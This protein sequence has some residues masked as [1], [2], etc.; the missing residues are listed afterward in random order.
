[1][2]IFQPQPALRQEQGTSIHAGHYDESLEEGCGPTRR[3]QVPNIQLR[4]FRVIATVVQV[5][6]MYMIIGT[7]TLRVSNSLPRSNNLPTPGCS[8][9]KSVFFCR[10]GGYFLDR[11]L[12]R[13]DIRGRRIWFGFFKVWGL[14]VCVLVAWNV[15]V[16]RW[17]LVGIRALFRFTL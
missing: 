14:C 17:A 2:R 8:S 4:G 13:F 10:R 1:M 11:G 3:V 16:A 5:L 7:W 6:G 9:I 12:G 15:L